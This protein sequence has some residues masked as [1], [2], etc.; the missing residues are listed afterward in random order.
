MIGDR[1]YRFIRTA[2]GTLAHKNLYSHSFGYTETRK[3]VSGASDTAVHAGFASATSSQTITSGITNPDVPRALRL[4]FSGTTNDIRAGVVEVH[5]TNVEGAVIHEEFV[6][7]DNQSADID[8]VKAFKTVTS[9]DVPPMDGTGATISVGYTNKLGVNHRLYANNTTV[10]VYTSTDV[11]DRIPPTLQGAPT[12]VAD[13]VNVE[14]NL[15]TPATAPD[16]STFLTICYVFDQ[17]NTAPV[18]D[19][20]VYATSTSTSTSTT[21]ATTTSTSTS[22]TSTSTSSTSTS[23]TTTSTSTSSTSTS[24]TTTP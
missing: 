3:K 13:E 12:V 17:W 6:L 10:K 4:A 11:D 14:Q 20:P 22:S 7:S 8:G 9:I 21:T 5:G 23:M 2:L 15:V 19:E 24:T 16:G 1:T 18:N